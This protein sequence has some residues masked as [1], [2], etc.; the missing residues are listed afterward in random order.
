MSVVEPKNIAKTE[1]TIQRQFSTFET[2]SDKDSDMNVQATVIAALITVTFVQTS[3]NASWIFGPL[4]RTAQ[5][6]D[7]ACRS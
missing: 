1:A 6:V 7:P 3:L 4:N 5:I 2:F